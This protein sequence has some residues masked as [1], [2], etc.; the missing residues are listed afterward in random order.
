MYKIR[1]HLGRGDNFMKWQVRST[2]G[3]VVQYY[4]PEKFQ[5]AM[6]NATLKVQLGASN[7][8]HEGACKTVCAWVQCEDFQVL[9]Q[10]D[11]VKKGESDFYVRFNPRVNPNWTD[12][13]AN[14]IND[15]NFNLLITEGRNI[16]AVVGHDECSE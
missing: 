7:K 16:F 12:A 2:D 3:N 14:R 10:S 15:E 11:L 6:F 9:G 5:I 13:S 4:E 8:I 1:F